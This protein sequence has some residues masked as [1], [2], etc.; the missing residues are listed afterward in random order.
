MNLVRTMAQNRIVQYK[1]L[2]ENKEKNQEKRAKQKVHII[3]PTKRKSKEVKGTNTPKKNKQN[4]N[5]KINLNKK[6]IQY[7][8]QTKNN[9]NKQHI[10][11]KIM[12]FYHCLF[13]KK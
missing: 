5:R 9:A 13:A 4:T 2:G 3:Q 6:L 1:K 10:K 8:E 12:P 7:N 11:I